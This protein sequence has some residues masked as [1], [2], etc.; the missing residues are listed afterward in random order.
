MPNRGR[1]V[2]THLPIIKR[3]RRKLDKAKIKSGLQ[4]LAS[5]VVP[6]VSK[7]NQF[8]SIYPWVET[9]LRS[10]VSRDKILALLRDSEFQMT[11]A[12]FKSYLQRARRERKQQEA[13]N[14]PPNPQGCKADPLDA[15]VASAGMRTAPRINSPGR[16]GNSGALP[17]VPGTDC[18]INSATQRHRPK[19]KTAA[20]YVL[21][22]GN[23][24]SP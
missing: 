11:L 22:S 14:A 2:P 23:W 4:V 7:M 21:P 19:T 9:A 13:L 24:P 6:Q 17:D 18:N 8:R 16:V 5:T 10:G 3:E 15:N 12:C 20:D 1:G